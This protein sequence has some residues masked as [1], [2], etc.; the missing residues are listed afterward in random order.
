LEL[1]SWS[2]VL[3][4]S[5]GLSRPRQAAPL[6]VVTAPRPSPCV[7]VL[8]PAFNAGRTLARAIESIRSQTLRGW[9]LVIVDDG[10]EDDTPEVAA[11]AAREDPRVRVV[12]QAHRGIVAALE[13][14]LAGAR[15]GLVARMDA[16]DVS[17]PERL[18]RQVRFLDDHPDI[19]VVGCAVEF[20]GEARAS[21]GFARHVAWLNS[22]LTPEAIALNR[23]IEAPL[24]H[25]SVMFRRGLLQ[26]HGGYR[27]GPFPEDYELWLRWI[28]RGVRLA[29]VPESLLVWN[30]PPGR[31][32]RQ[33]GRYA[34][35]AFYAVKS[36][37][38]A[39]VVRATL[40]G[41]ALWVWGA[42]RVTR[43]RVELLEAQGLE[44]RGFVD[45]DPAKWGRPRHG[46]LVVGPA[47]LPTPDQ[48][49]ILGY[50]AARGARE[51]IRAAVG[52]AGYV[53]GRDFWLAA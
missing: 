24:A 52:Q 47:D 44:V 15:A 14:G 11:A 50:V 39:R 53:E 2:L 43:R 20:G 45:V 51:L 22:L 28:E 8:L 13:T 40:A 49:L 36:P 33:D 3:G 48:A 9:E 25:P 31:L 6:P 21:E 4:A 26:E 34:T 19:G 29:K 32:S 38:L 10:S 23:F 16:D 46:R 17:R 35:T 12:R 7:S 1:G 18:E 27:D 37:Y 30:D 42:G 41:R 5:E